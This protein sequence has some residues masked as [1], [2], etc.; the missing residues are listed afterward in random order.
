MLDSL[1][2]HLLKIVYTRE[3]MVWH[4]DNAPYHTCDRQSLT[5]QPLG[6]SLHSINPFLSDHTMPAV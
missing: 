4:F 3:H 6:A 2:V 5:G 1:V